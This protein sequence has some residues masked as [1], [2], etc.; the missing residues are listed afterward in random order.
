MATEATTTPTEENVNVST[1]EEAIALE[2]KIREAMESISSGNSTP[3]E[4][5]IGK[6]LKDMRDLDAE[7]AKVLTAEYRPV[8]DEYFGKFPDSDYKKAVKHANASVSSI[9]IEE[10]E[11]DGYV[12]EIWPGADEFGTDEERP[13]SKR[14]PSA[15]KPKSVNRER[16]AKV[17]PLHVP[18]EKKPKGERDRSAYKFDGVEYGKG[19]LAQI[20]ILTHAKNNP[21]IKHDEMKKAFPDEILRSYGV[22]KKLAEALEISKVRKRYFLKDTQLIQLADCQIAV[23]NQWTSDNFPKFVERAKQLGF[24]IE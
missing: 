13:R 10:D 12:S 18:K 15:A 24:V 6:M 2:S 4:T 19:P 3:Q 20:I 16:A 1:N 7:R 9:I 17:R 5:G 14:G 8:S 22:F 21:G 11:D 23:C